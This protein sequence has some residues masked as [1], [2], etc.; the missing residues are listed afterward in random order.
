MLRLVFVPL[1]GLL[2]LTGAPGGTTD[3]SAARGNVVCPP[4][5]EYCIVG[6][7]SQGTPSV[8]HRPTHTS[9][10]PRTPRCRI[11]ANVLDAGTP[12]PCTSEFGV[13]NNADGCYYQL[14]TPQPP[15]S[16]PAW[17][18][19]Y[20]A[21]AIYHLTCFGYIGT[22]GGD[23]WFAT[24][25]AGL[26]GPAV[27]AAVLAQRAVSL[28]ALRGPAIGIAPSLGR[29]GL[30]GLPVWLWTGVSAH[31]WGPVSATATVPGLSVTAS[32][33]AQRITWSM[34]D[35]HTVTCRSPGTPYRVS[36]GGR[37]SPD[38][39]YVYEQPSAVVPGGKYRVVATTTWQVRWAGGGQAGVITVTRASATTVQIN[40]LQV[41]IS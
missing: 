1:A 39:G 13:W 3:A 27:S 8:T 22:G 29:P 24:P 30:V 11:P 19:H 32:A 10:A 16:D 6:A 28:L 26:A 15:A 40:E 34:G 9:V 4:V 17:E 21:G 12:E 7:E 18:G 41:L 14:A 20:P 33:R 35:G 36:L 37:R 5:T 23:G 25:P 2:L 31:T 38:C